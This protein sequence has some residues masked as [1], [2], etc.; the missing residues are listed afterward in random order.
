M[1]PK[2]ILFDAYGTL[3][4]VHSV[5]AGAAAGLS[6]DL[7]ALSQLWRRTQ[8][9]LTWRH[10]LMERYEDFALLTDRALR[11]SLGELGI[12]ATETQIDKLNRSYLTPAVFS[13]A[14]IALDQL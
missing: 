12:P 3:L 9:E 11:Q 2:A 14:R 13:D 8:L 1:H 7:A 6:G 5:I 4:D 10:A